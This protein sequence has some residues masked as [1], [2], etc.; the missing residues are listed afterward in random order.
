MKKLFMRLMTLYL[1]VLLGTTAEAQTQQIKGTV[2]D[3]RGAP[4]ANAS[5]VAKGSKAGTTT[6]E[7]GNFTLTVPSDVRT[8]VVSSINYQ[9]LEVPVT[10]RALTISLHESGNAK[11]EDVVVVG[12]GVQKK[13]N[14]TGAI[15]SVKAKDIEDMPTTRVEDALK[16]RTAG[17]TIVSASG[18]PGSNDPAVYIRGITSINGATPLYVVD[19]M[20][21]EGGIDYLNAADIESIEVLKDAA[22]AAIYGTKAAPGV[23]LVTTK[24]GKA[25]ALHV[26]YSGYY[27][28]QSPARELSLTNATQYATLRNESSLANGGGILFANPQSLGTGTNWQDA[29]FNKHAKIEN[30][31]LSFSGGN[32]KSTYNA[33]FGFFLQDGIVATQIS[34]YKRF[35][36]RVNGIH[37]IKPWLTFGESVGYA[38][39]RNQAPFSENG[40]YGGPLASAIAMDPTTPVVET[41]PTVLA[42]SMYVNN[43]AL[44]VRNAAGQPYA[45]S[46]WVQDE[47]S[48]PVAYQQTQIGNYGWGDKVVGNG[49]VEVE[50]LKGLKLKTS[51]GTDLAEWGSNSFDPLYYLS[52]TQNNTTTNNYTRSMNRANN[53]IFTNTASYTSKVDLHNFSILAGYESQNLSNEFGSTLIYN[54]IPATTFAQASMNY[55]I[56][57]SATNGYGFE[58]QPWTTASLFGRLTYD[59]DGRYLLTA[60][61]RRDGS[62]HFGSNNRYATFPSV[63]VG[64]NPTREKFWTPNNIVTYLKI[65]AGYG[66]N[67]NDNL[68]PFQYESVIAGAG[69]YVYGNNSNSTITTGYAPQTVA[70][71]NLKWEQTSQADVGFDAVLFNDFT[72]T[73]DW[74]KKKT[75][76]MLMQV[77]IPAYVGASAEPW[78]NV[79]SMQ[80]L[81]EELALGYRRKVGDVLLDWSGNVSY[82]KNEVTNLGTGTKFI[83]NQSFQSSSYEVSRT[84]VGHPFASF[85]GF[86][87]LGVFQN[88]AEINA[89]T[90]SKGN[91]LQPNAAPGDFK[92][93]HLSNGVGPIGS[94]DRTFTGNPLP[95]WTFGTTLSASYKGF[96]IK[97]F[98]QGVAGNKIFQE[99]RRIDIPASNY[100]TKY[101]NRW[102]GPGTS[103]T[104][105]RLI[106]GDPNGNFLNPSTFY[107]QNGAYF[108]IKTIQLGYTL[109]GKTVHTSAFEKVRFYVSG[110][111]LFTFT[112][113]DGFD[114][115]LGGSLL[116][117]DRGVYPQAKSYMV[118]ANLTF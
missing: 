62:S 30:H 66:I 115:E 42:G 79:A 39:T 109:Y 89:Y 12:Y 56:A 98:A 49:Y 100:S 59:Y 75:T 38:Y 105:P 48:N 81:G 103:N 111:N 118:G 63:S 108:R 107:L 31:S 104:M 35:T 116:G 73:F 69:S 24:A 65:R 53:W 84:M 21:V 46:P 5:V 102:T 16:G 94:A 90:D 3:E 101:L 23:I 29:I 95:T 74:F 112:K 57:T 64:W 28:T 88:Q 8:L 113:Y 58:N 4:L 77:A 97:A 80:N 67:G 7:K 85:Y 51:I 60:I 50:P 18:Q 6:D 72:V 54:G 76:G 83:T 47:M 1:L 33:S 110:N 106:D 9:S 52:P 10:G 36:V 68:S 43:S 82:I 20:V 22:S 11:L 27:G 93:A 13:S 78:G 44:L 55:T 71:P 37:K 86:Q 17:V 19:N 87:V 99:I 34:N 70:N 32:D 40:Y 91:I 2:S 45:I 92:Y 96:D 26:N 14:V 61:V 25:G 15:A 41:D 114:P 117:I